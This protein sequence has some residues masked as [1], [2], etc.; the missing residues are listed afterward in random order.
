MRIYIT[1]IL[2][3]VLTCIVTLSIQAQESEV[4]QFTVQLDSSFSRI[5]YQPDYIYCETTFDSKKKVHIRYNLYK[6][7]LKKFYVTDSC[8]FEEL[9]IYDYEIRPNKKIYGGISHSIIPCIGFINE[10][11]EDMIS[12]KNHYKSEHIQK[13]C[14]DLFDRIKIVKKTIFL[15]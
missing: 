8:S 2:H 9:A 4:K 5:K 15:D 13:F 7:D 12:E 10:D 11:M 6:K 14:L 3:T 1:I